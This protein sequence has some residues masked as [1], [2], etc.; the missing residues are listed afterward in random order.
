M[1]G[2]VIMNTNQESN[3][4]WWSSL[5]QGEKAVLR[6]VMDALKGARGCQVVEVARAARKWTPTIGCF[7][8][9]RLMHR[10]K[11]GGRRQ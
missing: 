1:K 10:R 5:P 8:K 2:K 4:Q 3:D 11:A 7:I 6:S 9:V